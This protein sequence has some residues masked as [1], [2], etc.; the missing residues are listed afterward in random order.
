MHLA[1]NSSI[2]RRRVHQVHIQLLRGADELQL[3]KRG[4]G[5][6]RPAQSGPYYGSKTH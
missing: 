1:M 5:S 3:L 6:S 2:F 4:A